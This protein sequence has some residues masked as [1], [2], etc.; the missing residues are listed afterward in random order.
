M[1]QIDRRILALLQEDARMGYQEIGEAVG[2]SGPAAYQRVRKLEDGGVVTGYHAAVSPDAVGRAMTAFLRVVPGP[3]AD[4][5]R[6]KDAWTGASE[7]QTCHLLS[8]RLGYLLRLSIERPSDLEPILEAA[9]RAGCEV[10]AELAL[11]TIVDRRRVPVFQTP[12]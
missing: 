1:D 9:R 7:V 6:L 8:G 2:L 3:T 4:V 10:H 12:K 11:A 5:E